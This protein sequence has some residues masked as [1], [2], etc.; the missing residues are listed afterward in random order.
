[1]RDIAEAVGV[2]AASLYAHVAG[3]ED[4]LFLIVDRVAEEFLAAIGP[5]AAA[6]ETPAPERLRRALAAHLAVVARN[7]A[8]ATVFF[9]DWQACAPE[10]RRVLLRKRDAYEAA[11]RGIV[12]DGI[13][14]GELRPC[15][16]RFAARCWLSV[17][18]WF[19]VWYRADGPLDPEAI[20]ARM[21][22]LLLEGMVAG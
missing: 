18:N 10:R 22:D 15:D 19:H 1:V 16:P 4:L 8:T 14:R 21:A 9:H 20:A 17:G 5:V 3:K 12:A 11:W 7:L 2:Q 6:R 13:E